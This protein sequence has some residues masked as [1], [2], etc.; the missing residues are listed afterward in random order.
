M[1]A[2]HEIINSEAIWNAVEGMEMLVKVFML[3]LL[4]VV[5]VLKTQCSQEKVL[6]LLQL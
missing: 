3:P 5:F 2:S 4:M 6:P 1:D